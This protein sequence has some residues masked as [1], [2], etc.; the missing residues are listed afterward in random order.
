MREPSAPVSLRTVA[1]IGSAGS[2]AQRS[3]PAPEAKGA[4]IEA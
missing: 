4:V 1:P 2:N 3:R